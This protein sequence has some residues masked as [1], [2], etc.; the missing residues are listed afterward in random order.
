MPLEKQLAPG[1]LIRGLTDLDLLV[2]PSHGQQFRLILHQHNIKPIVS[3]DRPHPAIEDYLG[4]DPDTGCLYHLHVHYQLVLG[5]HFV[6]NY[7]L[8]LEEAFWNSAQIWQGLVKIPTPEL[9][10]VVLAIRALLKYRDRDLV[11]DILSIRSPGLPFDILR[12]IEY[13]LDQTDQE[14]ISRTLKSQVGFISPEIVLELLATVV[15]SPR[16]G[17]VLYR[18]RRNLRREL[19]AYHGDHLAPSHRYLFGRE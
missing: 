9:E 8:P 14:R 6:K 7:H 2:D 11:K 1:L 16:A 19:R 12:E 13:L 15:H 10:L 18:L 5:E 17:W 4:F 3:P